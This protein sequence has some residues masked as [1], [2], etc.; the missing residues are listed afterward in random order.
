MTR[1]VIGCDIGGV[2]RNMATF[3][4]IRDSIESIN[5]LLESHDLIFISKCKESYK[6]STIEWLKKYNLSHIPIF[7]CET[8]K[9]K[10]QI[11]KNNKV[12]TMIDDK[13]AVLSNIP[14][15]ELIWFCDDLQKINGT[16]K[17]NP[18]V[19]NNILIMKD[20]NAVT[21]HLSWNVVTEHLSD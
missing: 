6:N 16:K 3:E 10:A 20:W 13:L 1:K 12:T 8:Y 9:D 21:E 14:D 4:P 11:I 15:I 5:K 2:V 19:L 7:F 17:Y 18:N